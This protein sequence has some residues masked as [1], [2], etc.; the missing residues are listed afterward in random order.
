MEC[1]LQGIAIDTFFFLNNEME[2]DAM[3]QNTLGAY[4]TYW[5]TKKENSYKN[6]KSKNSFIEDI[7]IYI[8]PQQGITLVIHKS[9]RV[10]PKTSS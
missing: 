2:S 8:C 7:Y 5:L 10:R 3:V 9:Q 1:D 6:S 4:V